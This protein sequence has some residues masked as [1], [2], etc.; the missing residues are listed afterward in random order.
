M[1]YTYAKSPAGWQG[2]KGF[3]S[4]PGSMI[5]TDS[6]V[7]YISRLNRIYQDKMM[8]S[9]EFC[10]N[11]MIPGDTLCIPTSCMRAYEVEI[12]CVHHSTL[13][14]A[15]YHQIQGYSSTIPVDKLPG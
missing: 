5:N 3:D 6:V 9:H 15:Q 1:G 4:L 11:L 13:R 12:H 8:H 7:Y 14:A 10:Q 2:L